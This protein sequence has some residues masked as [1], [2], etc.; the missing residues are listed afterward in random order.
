MH[1]TKKRGMIRQRHGFTL[2]E[3]LV[4]IA[5][6]GVLA[7][8][9]LAS[10]NTARAKARNTRRISD[11]RQISL[12][13]ELYYDTNNG[14]PSSG[15]TWRSQCVA[16][17]T[18]A[19][20]DV[21]PGL[22]PTYM[23]TFPADPSMAPSANTCCYLYN[24]NV[25]EYALLD[26]VCSDIPYTSQPSLLDPARDSGTNACT[27]DGTAFWSWKVSSPGGRCW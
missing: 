5:I 1:S 13:L 9:V 25:E 23:P 3:L 26:H 11:L 14:Y 7:S 16:W 24:S 22:V 20:S 15:G 4:V 2:I 27:I 19:A 18:Y 12:A 21:I 8:V 6:I 17:G 10:L